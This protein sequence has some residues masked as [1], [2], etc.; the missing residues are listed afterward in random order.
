MASTSETGH[1][2]NIANFNQL[3]VACTSLGPSYN[4]SNPLL[5]VAS[6]QL[7]YTDTLNQ[8]NVVTANLQ[9]YT[10]QVNL[11]QTVFADM[12]QRSTRIV[13]A[14]SITAN[15]DPKVV[16]DL[17]SILASIR[18]KRISKAIPESETQISVAQTSFNMWYDHFA[19]LVAL[20]A[21]IPGYAPNETDLQIININALRDS[22]LTANNAVVQAVSN[23]R[24]S[25]IGRNEYLYRAG[26]GVVDI[27]LAAKVYIGT[28]FGKNSQ[29]YNTVKGIKFTRVKIN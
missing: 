2:V 8:N 22:L 18:G 20:V 9:P 25:K 12:R 23:L 3:I 17:R 24:L 5:S 15:V 16:E 27:A 7:L 29:P 10:L 6:M 11:R 21:A 28:V 13:N 1:Y 14:A 4:P 26:D 19:K